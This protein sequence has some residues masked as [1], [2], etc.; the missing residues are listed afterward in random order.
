MIVSRR[1]QTDVREAYLYSFSMGIS[2]LKPAPPKTTGIVSRHL[3]QGQTN[4]EFQDLC[5]LQLFV[6]R[7]LWP[8]KHGRLSLAD[9][10]SFDSLF[11]SPQSLSQA[12]RQTKPRAAST[13]IAISA[14]MKATP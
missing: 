10:R 9:W 1:S 12:E 8:W 14:N 3:Q 13:A 2:V 5:S 11:L 6:R 7:M 4:L